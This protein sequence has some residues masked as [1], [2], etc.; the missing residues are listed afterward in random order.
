MYIDVYIDEQDGS[1]MT[2]RSIIS[3]SD[4]T[5]TQTNSVIFEQSF[6]DSNFY[7]ESDVF[8]T[9]PKA[10]SKAVRGIC[11]SCKGDFALCLDG[12]VKI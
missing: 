1:Q 11:W 10:G 6:F 5:Y 12:N 2:F 4:F 3:S 7:Y 9:M 8:Q